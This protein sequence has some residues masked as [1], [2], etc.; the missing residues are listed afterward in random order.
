MLFL[1]YVGKAGLSDIW[2]NKAQSVIKIKI[3]KK[4]KKKLGD[5]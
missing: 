3:K 2:E 5:H 4:K 1:R